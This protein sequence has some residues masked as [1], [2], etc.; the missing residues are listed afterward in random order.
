MATFET[1]D[2]ASFYTK[3]GSEFSNIKPVGSPVE[4]I[5]KDGQS[6]DKTPVSKLA[7]MVNDIGSFPSTPT[8]TGI[9]GI[10]FQASPEKTTLEIFPMPVSAPKIGIDSAAFS[11]TP[12]FTGTDTSAFSFIPG[13]AGTDTTPF[14]FVP[15]F[16]TPSLAIVNN[17]PDI[18]ATGFTLNQTNP[19]TD[20]VGISGNEFQSARLSTQLKI[21]NG[22]PDIDATGF[23]KEM[24]N[25]QFTG[26]NKTEFESPRLSTQLKVHNGIAD[27]DMSGFITNKGHYGPTDN[28][29]DK[30]ATGFTKYNRGQYKGGVSSFIGM[31]EGEA[32]GNKYAYPIDQTF[33]NGSY[34]FNSLMMSSVNVG[35][36]QQF[37]VL[38]R[39]GPGLDTNIDAKQHRYSN[40]QSDGIKLSGQW[41]D[42][43]NNL[44]TSIPGK[45]KTDLRKESS[46]FGSWGN[47]TDQPF[48][49]R[50]IGSNWSLFSDGPGPKFGIDLIRGGVGTAINRSLFDAARIGKFLI[51]PKG[52]LL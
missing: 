33:P 20:F 43:V 24:Q 8:K 25:T 37:S 10:P 35:A 1:I 30:A 34:N 28:I 38:A 19:S 31:A 41:E 18:D 44:Y 12:A 45:G 23:T 29:E 50:D 42:R 2:L 3:N 4:K 16:S 21:H 36:Q 51:S 9:D 7:E 11:F 49:L 46:N 32:N 22:M 14:G 52:L 39:S 6:S 13:F 47:A 15:G 26:I 27:I 5:G 17:S 40:N 48:I